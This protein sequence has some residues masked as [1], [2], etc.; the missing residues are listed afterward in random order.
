MFSQISASEDK[1]NF[2]IQFDYNAVVVLELKKAFPQDTGR[3]FNGVNKYWE[4]PAREENINS[5]LEFSKNF[6][7]DL[8]KHAK[9]LIESIKSEHITAIELSYKKDDS[10]PLNIPGFN[11][12]L[13]PYQSAGVKYAVRK[14]G[15]VLFGDEMGLGKTFQALATVQVLNGFPLLIVCPASLKYQWKAEIEK[16]L[17]GKDVYIIN[18]NNNKYETL[19]ADIIIINYEILESNLNN[20]IQCMEFN[21]IIF[22]EGYKIK[23][24]KSKR[25]KAALEIAQKC[26]IKMILNGTPISNHPIDLASQLEILGLLDK[27]FGGF[28]NFGKKYCAGMQSDFGWDFNGNSNLDELNN[29]LRSTCM[30]RRNQSEVLPELPPILRASIPVEISNR[31]EYWKA[32]KEFFN[33]LKEMLENEKLIPDEIKKYS[34]CRKTRARETDLYL[35]KNSPR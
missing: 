32:E 8:K 3:K 29:R 1:M 20:L 15:N 17:P 27:D 23:N 10:K 22:D 6:G 28:F 16:A 12:N 21:S 19:L 13:F 31:A 7:F 33:W 18:G 4:I 30:V 35:P 34:G 26:K 14:N 5:I 2:I 9:E 24:Q 11:I 25:T